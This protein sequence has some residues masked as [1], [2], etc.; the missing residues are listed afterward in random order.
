MKMI[1][2]VFRYFAIVIIYFSAINISLAA[3]FWINKNGN[4]NNNCSNNTTNSCLTIQKGI[5]LAGPGDTVN[6]TLGTY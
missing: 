4:D 2:S 5:S 6:I 3:D 1:D